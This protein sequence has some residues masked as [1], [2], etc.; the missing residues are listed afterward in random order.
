MSVSQII[1]HRF[2]IG[3]QGSVDLACDAARISA[4]FEFAQIL[5]PRNPPDQSILIRY[6]PAPLYDAF[7]DGLASILR[8]IS[9]IVRYQ[10]DIFKNGIRFA[11]L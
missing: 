1:L 6:N 11:R 2:S 9:V 8:I 10:I 7:Y 3:G 5:A 4:I